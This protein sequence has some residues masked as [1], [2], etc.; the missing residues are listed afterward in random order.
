M[1]RLKSSVL[2]FCTRGSQIILSRLLLEHAKDRWAV[3]CHILR[4]QLNKAL[5]FDVVLI[6][7]LSLLLGYF[8][9]L[10]CRKQEF[11]NIY[12]ASQKREFLRIK[13]LL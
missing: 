1:V 13:G 3:R 5:P 6:A 7:M 8:H 4:R 12:H 9:P 10:L 11:L 2:W